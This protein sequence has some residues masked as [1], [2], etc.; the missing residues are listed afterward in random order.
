MTD[1]ERIKTRGTPGIKQSSEWD[2]RKIFKCSIKQEIVLFQ[3]YQWTM[4]TKITSVQTTQKKKDVIQ[5]Q[6]MAVLPAQATQFQA[7]NLLIKNPKHFL[8]LPLFTPGVQH[9]LK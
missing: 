8:L 4:K 9:S 6:A 1:E 3:G 5:K 2:E 7:N